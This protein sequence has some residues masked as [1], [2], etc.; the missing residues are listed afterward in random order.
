M[1]VSFI[2]ATCS[3]IRHFGAVC[4]LGYLRLDIVIVA[5]QDEESKAKRRAME[6][7]CKPSNNHKATYRFEIHALRQRFIKEQ[8]TAFS[9][10]I[11]ILLFI[12]I[13]KDGW[14]Y[15]PMH[16]CFDCT[17]KWCWRVRNVEC[18]NKS[19]CINFHNRIAG[20][21][22]RAMSVQDIYG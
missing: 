2:F 3:W 12:V 5:P 10:L 4:C 14:L 17:R 1:C 22:V 19:R 6:K 9:F 8:S 13:I 21:Y 20:R 18:S 16:F 7:N 11:N 15:E